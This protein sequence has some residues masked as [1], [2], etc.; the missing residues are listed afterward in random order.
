MAD[1]I[2]VAVR[3]VCTVALRHP[4]IIRRAPI[5]C[6]FHYEDPRVRLRVSDQAG[7]DDFGVWV[8]A[9]VDDWITVLLWSPYVA[10]SERP[11]IF[12]P[13]DWIPYL[14]ALAMCRSREL[15]DWR[16][17]HWAPA[18]HEVCLETGRNEDPR[19]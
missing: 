15:L 12:L 7:I 5:G 6:Y 9:R 10:E 3:Y 18:R 1:N 11:Q 8:P 19:Q 17:A 16:A 14:R 4:S 2:D 13:G